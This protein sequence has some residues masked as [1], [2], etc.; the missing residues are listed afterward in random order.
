LSAQIFTRTDGIALDTFFVNDA[1]TGNLATR[2]QHDQFAE[3][4][5]KVLNGELVAIPKLIAHQITN[6]PVYEAYA[7]ER[8]PTK[9]YFDNDASDARTLIEIE[10]EDQLGLLYAISQTFAELSVDIVGA[11]IV[12]ERGAAIDSFYVRELDGGKLATPERQNYIEKKLRE[13]ISRFVATP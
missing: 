3:L 2:A 7:G 13:A 5:E 6:R 12:T 4:L 10:T 11:R 8:M 1:R 9:I